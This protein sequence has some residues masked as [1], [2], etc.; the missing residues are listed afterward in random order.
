MS[1]GDY[2]TELIATA[3]AISSTGRG[4]LAADESTG[5]IGKRLAG[6]NL[7]NTHPNRQKYRELLFKTKG[8]NEYISGCILYEE[9]LFDKATCGTPMVDLLKAAKIIPG[10]K[11]DMGVKPLYGTDGE[12]VTQGIT[13]LADR[14][15]KYYKQG[16]RFSKWRAVMKISGSGCPSALAI[17]Q[18]AETLARYGAISQACGLVPIIEPEVLMDGTHTIE[19]A[20][21]VTEKVIAATFKALSDHHILLEGCLLKPN[22]VRKGTDCK[23]VVTAT[24]IGNATCRVLQHTV[25]V[26][27]PGIM[28]LSGGMSEEGATEA[29]NAVNNAAPKAKRPWALSFSFG[30]ALQQSVLKA[31]QGKD[32]NIAEA[33]KQ[34]MIRA[35]ANSLACQGLYKGEGKASAAAADNLTVKNYVY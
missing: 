18:N 13:G 31:W 28:F 4:I 32:E 2:A 25:P 34:L 9:T 33:Q 15:T 1:F 11:V 30:R 12:T 22:M 8:L 14:C 23:Q 24:D 26:A 35:K 10:I 21:V 7:E 5:T 29:L 16:A 6:I 3:N 17:K 19:Q 20:A 27:L